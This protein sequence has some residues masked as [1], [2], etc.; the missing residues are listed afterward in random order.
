MGG[1][2]V[3]ASTKSNTPPAGLASENFIPGGYDTLPGKP[4][5]CASPTTG[6]WPQS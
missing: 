4:T 5:A 6:R 3:S 1:A 2:G